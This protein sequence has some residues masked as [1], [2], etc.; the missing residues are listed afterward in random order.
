MKLQLNWPK[1]QCT[2]FVKHQMDQKHII[3]A[4]L[5]LSDG[6][7]LKFGVAGLFGGVH[8]CAKFHGHRSYL[9]STCF[10][11]FPSSQKLNLDDA[12]TWV[13][14]FCQNLV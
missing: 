14:G 2:S 9:A 1:E 13:M 10:T 11:R 7:G 8:K 6:I 12:L 5:G 4:G 3:E